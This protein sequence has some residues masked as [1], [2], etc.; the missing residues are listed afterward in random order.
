MIFLVRQQAFVQLLLLLWFQLRLLP[1]QQLL[2]LPVHRASRHYRKLYM[3]HWCLFVLEYIFLKLH[4]NILYF[5]YSYIRVI[6]A[7]IMDIF[8]I[9]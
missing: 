4:I 8:Q 2:Q 5:V 9:I 3:S 6:A 7:Y 1:L